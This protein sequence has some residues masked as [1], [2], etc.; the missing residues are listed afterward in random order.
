MTKVMQDILF[1]AA[2]EVAK[3]LTKEALRHG[4]QSAVAGLRRKR[5]VPKTEG[6]RCIQRVSLAV[7]ARERT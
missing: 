5:V 4:L 6:V 1:L 2:R 3:D 7:D